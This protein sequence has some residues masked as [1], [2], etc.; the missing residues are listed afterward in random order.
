MK[1]QNLLYGSNMS[2]FRQ[3]ILIFTP[4]IILLSG[5]IAIIG[6]MEIKFSLSEIESNETHNVN[7][8]LK[9]IESNLK[10]IIADLLIIATH[11]EM[12][13]FLD[14]A[15][16]VH[17]KALENELHLF[18]LVKKSYDQI[19]YIDSSGM[20][21]V[22]INYKNGQPVVV[23]E[24]K[25]Q[26]KCDRYYFEET[27]QMDKNEIYA[28]PFDLNVEQG[29]IEQPIKPMI[30]VG[31]PV[32]DKHNQKRGIVIINYL[33]AILIGALGNKIE[34]GQTIIISADKYWLINADG[35]W[36]KGSVPENEWG[37]M[38]ENRKNKTF[39]NR[40]P[41]AWRH[42][43]SAEKGQVYSARGLFTFS[44]VRPFTRNNNH[45]YLNSALKFEEPKS[46]QWKIISFIPNEVIKANSWRVARNLVILWAVLAVVL[47][48]V[49]WLFAVARVRNQ[50]SEIQLRK[51]SRAVEQSASTIVITDSDGSIEFVNPAFSRITGYSYEEAIGQNPRVLKSDKHS[52]EFYKEM[53]ATLSLG[54]VWQGEII[55]KKK[56]DELYW[57]SAT[58]SPI[59]DPVGKITHYVAIKDDITDRKR[60]EEAFKNIVIG[61]SSKEGDS[62][63]DSMVIQLAKALGADY[64]LIGELKEGDSRSIR[65]IS[66]C[67]KGEIIENIEYNL[68]GTPCEELLG[69]N[70]CTYPAHVVQTFPNDILLQEMNIE[71]YAGTPLT[72]MNGRPSGIMVALFCQPI[73][74]PQFVKSILQIF[75]AQVGVEIERTRAEEALK[76]SE[77]RLLTLI[78]AVPD[79]ICFKDGEGRWL[80]A[81][82]AILDLFQLNG[83]DYV[84]KKERELAPISPFFL[85]AFMACEI[86]DEQA[87]QVGGPSRDEETIP[88]PD[89]PSVIYDIIKVP[90]F[91]PDGSRNALVVFGRD[92]TERKQWENDLK[93]AKETAEAANRAKSEFLANMSHEIRTPMNAVLGFADILY[94]K[95]SDESHLNYIDAIRTGGQ[96]LLNLIND[97]LDLSKIEAGKMEIESEPVDPQSIFAEIKQIF[98]LKII[99]KNLA[100]LE[101]ISADIPRFMYLDSQRLRQTLLNLVGNALKFTAKGHIKL[102]ADIVEHQTDN[103]SADLIITVEDTGIGIPE[104]EQDRIF[105]AFQQQDQQSTREFGGTGLGLTITK[106]LV[107]MMNGDIQVVSQPGQ[108]ST[109][110]ITLRDVQFVE[111][112]KQPADNLPVDH[113]RLVFEPAVI[114]IA[115][116]VDSNLQLIKAMLDETELT[117]IEA[118]NGQEAIEQV[119][120]HL[121]DLVLMDI[122]MPVMDGYQATETIKNDPHYNGCPIIALTASAMEDEKEKALSFGFDNFLSKPLQVADLLTILSKYLKHSHQELA[123]A[124]AAEEEEI[125]VL[126]PETLAHLPEILKKFEGDYKSFWQKVMNNNDFTDITQFAEHIRQFGDKWGIYS[127]SEFGRTLK[128]YCDIFDV[129]N[130]TNTL[131][132]YPEIIDRLKK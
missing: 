48:I 15:S 49:S 93:A 80:I 28:S 130:I 111:E 62:F 128:E 61:V 104:K 65:T 94:G 117:M 78:N 11:H 68:A 74:N 105:N 55:N 102:S 72:D 100:W 85:D 67:A 10:P 18:S 44:T 13:A 4:I 2:V 54:E 50:Q 89:S 17:K 71:G 43:I 51:L 92:I 63:F 53:W 47:A 91:N 123:E 132:K 103:Q 90:M 1:I 66:F 107:E 32:F 21:T 88:R 25:L 118:V 14:D 119:S 109:F 30:R 113:K 60:A 39:A 38:Y 24:D 3:F 5:I 95:V 37:F 99:D 35:F 22:R 112:Q 64:T 36:L 52:A 120:L 124:T 116:D 8:Q 12:L 69:T 29:Q 82:D 7:L 75:A 83:V 98:A 58:I 46:Y 16:D 41:D 125:D 40:F 57:E 122:R 77:E 79:I 114:L 129:E 126:S 108:G 19:R 110:K 96:A 86:T 84:G 81:N 42:L 121:P 101:D 9:M 56:N 97:I 20:E 31:M 23:A 59:K 34:T 76:T 106:R 127:V 45:D 115:D 26:N 33:G 70:E 73:S 6:F 131:E 27:F 87:W